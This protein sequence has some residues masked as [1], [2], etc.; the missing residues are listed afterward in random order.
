MWLLNPTTEI[1]FEVSAKHEVTLAEF[2]RQEVSPESF[3]AKVIRNLITSPDGKYV[4]FNAIGYLWKKDL[5]NGSPKR[6]TKSKDFEYE[7]AFHPNGNSIIYVT[8]NDESYGSIKTLDLASGQTST[9]GTEKGI[10]R[11]PSYSP[12]GKKLVYW[13]ES[14]NEYQ[15]YT[16][17]KK[18]GIYLMNSD[19]TNP[20]HISEEGEYPEFNTD[21]S[22][23]YFQTGGYL[24]GA[25]SKAYHSVDLSG[26]DKITH[27]T[28]QYTTRFIPSPD[29]NWIAFNELHNA[30]IAPF[31]KAGEPIALSKRH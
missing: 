4:I 30:Y 29:G 10:F 14:G 31:P 7:P 24:F 6:L 1:P 15:G 20:K 2:S 26:N 8:W 27:F 18:S 13:K 17:S 28:S 5:P 11:E 12:D 22:R 3:N 23:V 21:G 25:L 16:W 19:G 9:I